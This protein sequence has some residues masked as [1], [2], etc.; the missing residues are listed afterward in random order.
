MVISMMTLGGI[1][2]ILFILVEWKLARLPMMPMSIFGNRPV[3]SIL[4]QNFFFGIAFYGFLYYL[5]LYYQ[6]V[7][8]YSVLKSAFLTIPLTTAQSIASICSGQY[9]SR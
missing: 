3:C 5:P 4:V 7:K 6:N 1:F 2:L 8:Q 9:I